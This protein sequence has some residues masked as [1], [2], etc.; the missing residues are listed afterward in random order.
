MDSPTS[1]S[2]TSTHISKD[3]SFLQSPSYLAEQ[4]ADSAVIASAGTCEE[5][6]LT[7]PGLQQGCPSEF[8]EQLSA[9]VKQM[10]LQTNLAK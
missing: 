3:L 8:R 2:Y 1:S 9:K 10:K 7:V 4:A 6:H 5:H